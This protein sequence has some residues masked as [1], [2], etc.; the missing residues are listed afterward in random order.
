MARSDYGLG[1]GTEHNAQDATFRTYT[2]QDAIDRT[3]D[4][5]T[6]GGGNGQN[7]IVKQSV[8]EAYEELCEC[9]DWNYFYKLHRI[10]VYAAVTGTC[11]YTASTRTFTIDSG[12]WPTW[13]TSGAVVRI[14]NVNYLINDQTASTT[15]LADSVQCP[16]ANI[17]TGTSFSVFRLYYSLPS[18]FRSM[19]RPLDSSGDNWSDYVPPELWSNSQLYTTTSG[20]TPWCWTVMNHPFETG[21]MCV[22]VSPGYDTD[23]SIEMMIQRYPRPLIYDGIQSFCRVGTVAVSTADVTGTST[24]FESNMAG[25]VLRIAR[26]GATTCPD[27]QGGNNPYERQ[28]YIAQ[29]TITSTGATIE[30]SW[31]GVTGRKY[32]ISDPIDMSPAMIVAFFRGCEYKIAQKLTLKN[33]QQAEVSYLKALAIAKSADSP[34]RVMRSCWDFGLGGRSK[35][36]RNTPITDNF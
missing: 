30:G 20:S 4:F 2:Y 27:G 13:A 10:P 21:R 34:A 1:S 12:S 25:A 35:F 28:A 5:V 33:V 6:S 22:A 31:S 11:S 8:L 29:T 36:H 19:T 15:L 3:T 7:R 9:H 16:A 26:S 23:R 32:T 14:A 18:D 17:T 24:T